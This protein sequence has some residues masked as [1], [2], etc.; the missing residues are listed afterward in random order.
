MLLVPVVGVPHVAAITTNTSS[1]DSHPSGAVFRLNQLGNPIAVKDVKS[2]YAYGNRCPLLIRCIALHPA[3]HLPTN[4]CFRLAVTVFNWWELDG[5]GLLTTTTTRSHPPS[6]RNNNRGNDTSSRDYDTRLHKFV[7][8]FMSF[9]QRTRPHA[10]SLFLS[11]LFIYKLRAL[12]PRAKGEPGCTHR[13]FVVALMLAMRYIELDSDLI[14]SHGYTTNPRVHSSVE[15]R[16]I[17]TSSSLPLSFN[18]PSSIDAFQDKHL[19]LYE[20]ESTECW[21]RLSSPLF[22]PSD[23]HKMEAEM[24][25]F[26]KYDLYVEACELIGWVERELLHTQSLFKRKGSL[27]VEK[28]EDEGGWCVEEWMRGVCMTSSACPSLIDR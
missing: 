8:Y 13:L 22:S 4:L 20:L 3:L 28:D 11:V 14:A 10:F 17:P 7:T 9:V 16:N 15:T 27:D 21:A 18:D 26:L 24:M 1:L 12:H 23:L 25:A 2:T 5:N 6:T 19:P